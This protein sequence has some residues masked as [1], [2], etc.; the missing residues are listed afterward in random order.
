MIDD[1]TL[2]A[3]TVT[4]ADVGMY[5]RVMVY[6]VVPGNV[7]QETASLT[8]DYP[9]VAI[10]AGANELE[11]DPV[12]VS[13]EVAEGKKGMMVGAPVTATGN[14]G[15]VNYALAGD[16]W[17]RQR[18]IQDRPEDWPDNNRCGPGL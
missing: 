12:D 16:W 13:R 3:Y 15:A 2:A 7:D 1:E 11:F 6:Y 10:R 8:S 5:L 18:Q 4:T 14:H 17:R 9:V